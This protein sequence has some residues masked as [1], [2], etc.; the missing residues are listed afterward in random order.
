MT[1][2]DLDNRFKF[3]PAV[4]EERKTAHETVRE[5]VGDLASELNDYLPEG[6]EKALV[7]TKLEEAMFWSNAA[8]AR[9][10]DER[11]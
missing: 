8:I 9:Q 6:R 7:I 5:L 2:E 4:T 11:V 10:A 3:H 1:K